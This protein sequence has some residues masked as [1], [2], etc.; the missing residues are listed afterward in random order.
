MNIGKKH[1]LEVINILNSNGTLNENA[2]LHV[3]EDRF[4]VRKSIVSELDIS[5]VILIKRGR[6]YK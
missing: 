5:Q 3:G 6:S 1:D 2:I 4:E